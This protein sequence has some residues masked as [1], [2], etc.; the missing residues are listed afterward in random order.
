MHSGREDIQMYVDFEESECQVLDV[1][2]QSM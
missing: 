2:F 1:A